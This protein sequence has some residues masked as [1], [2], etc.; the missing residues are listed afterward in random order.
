MEKRRGGNDGQKDLQKTEGGGP[1]FL[2]GASQ[3]IWLGDVSS[4]QTASTQ[5]CICENNWIRRIPEYGE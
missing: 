5:T 3:Y 4:V 1:V 2:R